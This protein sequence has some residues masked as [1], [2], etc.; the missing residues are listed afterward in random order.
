MVGCK[1]IGQQ[2]HCACVGL[3]FILNLGSS[4]ETIN[5]EGDNEADNQGINSSTGR[6]NTVNTDLFFKSVVP[7]IFFFIFHPDSFLAL[8]S[9]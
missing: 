8:F 5:V 3:T 6:A 2:P 7:E 1:Y 9:V 4:S